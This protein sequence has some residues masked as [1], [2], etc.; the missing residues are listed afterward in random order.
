MKQEENTQNLL[1]NFLKQNTL[2]NENNKFS[3]DFIRRQREFARVSPQQNECKFEQKKSLN[4]DKREID[5]QETAGVLQM[6]ETFSDDFKRFFLMKFTEELIKRSEKRDIIKLQKIIELKEKRKREKLIPF[7]GQLFAPKVAKKIGFGEKILVTPVSK[8][9]RRIIKVREIAK[10]SL[11]IPE[12]K[13]PEHLEYLKP[14]PT[15]GIE[16]DLFKLNPLIK[17]PA[18][19]IIEVN[20]DEKVTVT[21]TMGTKPT[22]IILSKEDINRVISKFSEISK[23]PVNEGIYR[24]VAGNL[25]LSAIISEVIGSK[26][27]IKKMISSPAQQQYSMPNPVR[28]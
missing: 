23:I 11:F 25:I 7:K 4:R 27:I 16:I 26:F 21:G 14:V 1:R 13:L 12:P 2:K 5:C 10:P 8:P 17:D 15:A 20:P 24:V 18:V 28:R 19:R 22:D 9:A 3:C 6:K